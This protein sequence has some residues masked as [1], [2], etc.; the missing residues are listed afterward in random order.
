MRRLRTFDLE[1]ET[2]NV[3]ARDAIVARNRPES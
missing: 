2:A 1:T 3:V